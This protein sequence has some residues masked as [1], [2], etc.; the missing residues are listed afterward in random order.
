MLRNYK[1]ESLLIAIAN[2]IGGITRFNL[3]RFAERL[4]IDYDKLTELAH[5]ARNYDEYFNTPF[6]PREGG[7]L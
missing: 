7:I 1:A 2:G 5:H 4:N 6:T 3:Y